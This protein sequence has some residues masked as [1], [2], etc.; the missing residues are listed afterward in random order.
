MKYG[1]LYIWYKIPPSVHKYQ[2]HGSDINQNPMGWFSEEPQEASHKILHEARL[3]FIRMYQRDKTNKDVL[4][5]LLLSSDP[6]LTSLRVQR[7]KDSKILTEEAKS[8]LIEK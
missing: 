5:Y 8:V 4:H 7:D 2:I 6:L 1:D 3:H